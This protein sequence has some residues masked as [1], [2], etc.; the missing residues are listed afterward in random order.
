[1]F[2]IVFLVLLNQ[3]M[4]YLH[5][6]I[7]ELFVVQQSWSVKIVVHKM[8]FVWMVHAYALLD[9]VGLIVVPVYLVIIHARIATEHNPIIVNLI[10]NQN[11][12]YKLLFLIQVIH[13]LKVLTELI[14]L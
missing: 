6:L 9:A 10:I 8:E 3:P 4:V 1:M 7:L 5:V 14:I 12:Y 13:A 11:Y 2:K